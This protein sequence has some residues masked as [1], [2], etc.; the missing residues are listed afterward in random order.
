MIYYSCTKQAANISN[1]YM[2]DL[3]MNI[4]HYYDACRHI[5]YYNQAFKWQGGYVNITFNEKN[6][7][8]LS[9]MIMFLS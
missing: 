8:S 6:N 4:I 3:F 7:K 1:I 5:S 2:K 9:F